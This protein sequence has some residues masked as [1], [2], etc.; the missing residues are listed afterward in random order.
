MTNYLIVLMLGLILGY[1]VK[2]YQECPA[3]KYNVEYG[4]RK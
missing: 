3:G 4:C 2:E 1:G